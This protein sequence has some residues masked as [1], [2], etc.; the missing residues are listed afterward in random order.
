MDRVDVYFKGLSHVFHVQSVLAQFSVAGH[1]FTIHW[2][3]AIIALGFT[4]AAL[5]GGRIAYTWKM[6]LDKM[7]DVLIYGTIAGVI[8][9]R[10]Y[11]GIF[12]WD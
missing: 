8:C 3:G 4:L 5:L 10:L 1:S 12:E 7:V 11:D 2:Y 9:A 6:S